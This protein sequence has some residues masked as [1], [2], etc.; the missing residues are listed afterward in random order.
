M[1][2]SQQS[3]G[4]AELLSA[5]VGTWTL[6]ATATTVELHTK[7]MWGL[8]KVKASLTAVEGSAE[9]GADGAVSG[10]LVVDAASIDTGNAKRD[11]HLRS[12]D[13]FEVETYPTFTYSAAS[14]APTAD[15]TIAIEG[16][17]TIHGQTR[18]LQLL[19][20]TTPAGPDRV[21]VSAETDIDRTQWGLTWTKMGAGIH[22]HLIITSVFTKS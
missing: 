18:P 21:T 1:T 17:L 9:V 11:V 15:G 22:N 3:A 4:A 16:T 19:A 20:T 7:A 10:T 6:D 12:K 8:A 14:A 2:D 13:F 5:S